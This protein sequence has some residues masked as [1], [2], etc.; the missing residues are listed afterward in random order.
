MKNNMSFCKE[1]LL[2]FC[3]ICIVISSCK[4]LDET[5]KSFVTPDNFYTTPAQI[6]ATF[7][8]SMN[9]LWSAWSAYG[10]GMAVFANDDQLNGGDLN[11]P[12]N[13]GSDLWAAHYSAILNLNA[14]IGAME[15]GKLKDIAQPDLD[16]LMGQAK[17]LR[18]YN[19]FM[20]VRMFGD[21]PLLTEET[22]DPFNAKIKRSP[23]AD[24]YKLITSDFTE[25]IAKLPPT[26]PTAEKGRP[27]ADAAKGLLAKAYLTMATFPLN[28]PEYYQKAA[29]LA[30][31]IIKD[32]HYSLVHD[33]NDVFS[34]N[35][36]FGP[37]V[38]WSFTSNSEDMATDP[39]IWSD[40]D[41]W[42]DESADP[43]WVSK[44]PDQPRKYAYV[45]I[46]SKEG[47]NYI[48]E[49]RLPGIKKYL[50][51][52]QSDFDAGRSVITIPVIRYADVLLIFAEADNMAHG[53]PTQAAV[54]AVNQVI[55]R[56]NGYTANAQDPLATPGMPKDAFDTKVIQERNYELC[57][58]Y[59]RWFD[60]IRKH[61]LKQMSDPTIQ[62]NFS[63]DD[64]LFPIP[65]DDIRLN[66]LLTQNPG[67]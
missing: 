27:T 16:V 29:D 23:V 41:G 15:G 32:G 43:I 19:Y 47:D 5:P 59:D 14:A 17:F 65:T 20:L 52:T 38:M 53:G 8:S 58:E 56:A 4:K 61:I 45:Q 63:E 34:I 6:E 66:P 1:L 64:Y 33:I 49:G 24:V 40:M 30:D 48:D 28:E 37:E 42:G 13:W 51:D 55:E 21:L 2:S 57:F 10:Y 54:D 35:T 60:L 12:E 39:H 11:I 3:I 31:Q 18:A 25:A 9:S 50:Y 46:T 67:Y 36:Q 22:A 62:Q 26:W 7:A 44:Y